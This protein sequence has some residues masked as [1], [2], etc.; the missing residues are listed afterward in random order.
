MVNDFISDFLTRIR[1]SIMVNKKLVKVNYSKVIFKLSE[2]LSKEGYIDSFS[3]KNVGIKKHIILK[4]KYQN[5]GTSVLLGLKRLSKSG[6]RIYASSKKIP[7]IRNGIGVIVISTSKGIMT[8]REAKT[9]NVG[10]ELLFS[11]W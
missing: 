5:N 11:I 9:K 7:S 3:I 8:S 2:L 10:G 6:L 1:N 4:L